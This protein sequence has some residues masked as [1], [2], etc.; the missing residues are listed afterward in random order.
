[1]KKLILLLGIILLAFACNEKKVEDSEY[2][3]S[4]K[5]HRAEKDSTMLV[6]ETSPFN[7][8]GEI[9]FSPLI[10]YPIDSNFVYESK[11]TKYEAPEAITIYGT[12]GEKRNA[13][14]FGYLDIKA[15]TTF[16]LNV[17]QIQISDS[18]YYYAVW[19]TDKTTASETY[20]VGRYLD[21]EYEDNPDKVYT[22]DFNL[23]YNPWCAYNIAYS[24]AVPTKEDHLPIAITAGEKKFH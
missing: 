3:K 16:K 24:C 12:Q 13:V 4:I 6:S 20:G 19:F 15:D 2:V 11:L 8:K 21:F 14:R 22:I 9:K 1:M 10:Y 17:Y 23:A 18:A 7:A 5:A